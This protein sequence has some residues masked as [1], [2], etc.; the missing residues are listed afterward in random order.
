MRAAVR[1]GVAVALVTVIFGG[2]SSD[3]SDVPT[4]FKEL[5]ARVVAK[6][7]DGFVAQTAGVYDTGPTDLAKAVKDDGAPNAHK[8]LRS[9]GFVRG[10]QRIWKG[11][12]HAGIIVFLYQFDST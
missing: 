4:S 1:A 9:E 10:Y 2:C 3:S 6:A 5:Q 12:E 8:L 7:P 11:P